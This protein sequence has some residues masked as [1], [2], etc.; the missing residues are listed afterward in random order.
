MSSRAIAHGTKGWRDHLDQLRTHRATC[1]RSTARHFQDLIWAFPQPEPNPYQMEW[2]DLID[3]IRDDT[4]L[5]RSEARCRRPAWSRRWDAWP[6]TPARS[7]TFDQ[8]LNCPHEFAPAIAQMSVDG[9][10]PIQVNANGEYPV[11]MPGILT[12]REYEYKV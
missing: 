3:A 9:P 4:R 12:D 5:Q 8:M 10:A 11:P 1:G 7:I 6:P 2:E